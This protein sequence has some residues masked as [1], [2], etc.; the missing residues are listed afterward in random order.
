MVVVGHFPGNKADAG[1]Q[2]G[3]SGLCIR[4]NV[5]LTHIAMAKV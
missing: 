5:I 3:R 2:K 1:E 4:F